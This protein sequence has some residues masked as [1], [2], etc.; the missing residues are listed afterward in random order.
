MPIR[1]KEIGTGLARNCVH[2]KPWSAKAAEP[3][4]GL[5]FSLK[6]VST[7]V[8][9]MKCF[10]M[11]ISML[12]VLLASLRVV[13]TPCE[14]LFIS[15][16]PSDLGL[17]HDSAPLRYI[18]PLKW[19]VQRWLG[20]PVPFEGQAL[21]FYLKMTPALLKNRISH[22][23]EPVT[24]GV[25]RRLERLHSYASVTMSKSEAE[26]MVEYF[27]N[28]LLFHRW[29]AG[30]EA[31]LRARFRFGYRVDG[32]RSYGAFSFARNLVE[33]LT[34]LRYFD[35]RHATHYSLN[36]ALSLIENFH[37][38][39][40]TFGEGFPMPKLSAMLVIASRHELAAHRF[41]RALAK[42]TSPEGFY[43]DEKS[44]E[45]LIRLLEKGNG[46]RSHPPDP[47]DVIKV[48]QEFMLHRMGLLAGEYDAKASK[49]LASGSDLS[50]VV[51]DY[52][53]ELLRRN[54]IPLNRIP[55][56]AEQAKIKKAIG[57]F[58]RTFDV[59]ARSS[60]AQAIEA[61]QKA[62]ADLERLFNKKA[63]LDI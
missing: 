51:L 62:L 41:F 57:V 35:E 10:V 29:H 32:G 6:S 55:V 50:S 26:E 40:G 21:S 25:D 8:S 61:S 53:D 24:P 7:G 5:E 4:Q 49:V 28:P 18:P 12:G 38:P 54:E 16:R 22:P 1:C 48:T 37:Y 31:H 17:L 27:Y 34:I 63:S 20:K 60:K 59:W 13:A 2:V 43:S 45:R 9:Y 46:G 52:L 58:D 19:Q 42:A 14:A 33:G 3:K 11:L 23:G 39:Q 30:S 15:A 44:H 36:A 56:R 47:E